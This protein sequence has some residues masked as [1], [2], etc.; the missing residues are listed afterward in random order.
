M[1]VTLRDGWRELRAGP[2]TAWLDGTS[3]RRIS[4]DGSEII[5]GIVF[6][7]RDEAWNTIPAEI[8]DLVVRE[9][10]G[11]C[12]ATFRAA[13]VAPGIAFKWAASLDVLATGEVRYVLDGEFEGDAI[14]NRIGFNVLFAADDYAGTEYRLRTLDGDVVTDRF[15]TLVAAQAIVD[16][17][18][19]GFAP[20]FDRMELTTKDEASA[21]LEFGGDPYELEDQR[22]WTDASYKAYTPPLAPSTRQTARAG[23]RLKQSVSIA[24][25]RAPASRPRMTGPATIEVHEAEDGG[26]A[27]SIG[28]W[29]TSGPVSHDAE[30]RLVDLAPSHLRV[31]VVPT[32][33]SVASITDAAALARLCGANLE[34]ALRSP[35]A[36]G[37][38]V[39]DAAA[40]ILRP[41][42]D[43]VNLVLAFAP[44]RAGF[45]VATA[46][47]DASRIREGL[48]ARLGPIRVG[49]GTDS[50]FA[51]INRSDMTA[52]AYETVA[53]SLSPTVHAADTD[54][55]VENLAGLAAPVRTARAR[56]GD[57]PIRIGPITLQT[58]GGPYPA[59]PSSV[60][61]PDPR[62]TTPFAA[63][64]AIAVTA[65]LARE[66]VEALTFLATT[67][68]HGVLA[69]DGSP[70]PV[71]H[72]LAAMCGGGTRL[73][74]TTTPDGVAAIAYRAATGT[75]LVLAS[76]SDQAASITVRGLPGSRAQVRLIDGVATERSIV[77][78]ELVLDVGPFEAFVIGPA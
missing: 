76:M 15:P 78:G 30:R 57:T 52:S 61:R 10:D 19:T 72:A 28:V 54:S 32:A 40:A 8:A 12:T 24:M 21:S 2:V 13:H 50:F 45:D 59:G 42:L 14:F 23:D 38:E 63:A 46:A 55:I 47:G 37:D 25:H 18:L 41:H 68:L 9:S 62:L 39:F 31:D 51:A 56:V 66:H 27:P 73:V 75:R 22:N 3:L 69:E 16:E 34:V 48:Q 64:W 53:W 5:Q 20:P 29:F 33:G 26:P 35:S 65:T 1:A 74:R 71:Y 60:G 58:P 49:S 70:L 11:G 44:G 43:V 7:V 17:H 4:I 77:G 36:A 67:G 6:A